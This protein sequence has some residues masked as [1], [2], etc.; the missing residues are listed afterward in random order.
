[1]QTS[2]S[3]IVIGCIFLS[4][5]FISR[6]I[7]K[8]GLASAIVVG[9]IKLSRG[10]MKY[11]IGL[12]VLSSAAV[13]SII[14]NMITLLTLLPVLALINEQYKRLEDRRGQLS[15]PIVIAV[16]Y[17]SN[18]GGM[19]SI[20]GSPANA[21]FLGFL[22]VIEHRYDTVIAGKAGITLFTWLAFGVPMAVALALIAWLLI[23]LLLVPKN[24]KRTELDFAELEKK[25]DFPRLPRRLG[26]WFSAGMLFLWTLISG[27]QTFFPGLTK[28][29]AALSV[30]L[31]LSFTL[32]I[33]LIK[34]K[35]DQRAS[36][37]ILQVRDCFTGLPVQGLLLALFAGAISG[38]SMLLKIPN[39]IGSWISGLGLGSLATPFISTVSMA[40]FTSFSTEFLSNTLVAFNFFPIAYT[41]SVAFGL[42]P[43]I[44]MLAVSLSTTCAF[45]SPIATPVNA[46]GFGSLKGVSFG[47]M[48]LA[49]FFMNIVS[50][51]WIAGCV[52]NI[53]PWLLPQ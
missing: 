11:L 29:L 34:I 36:M 33:F 42:N 7:V 32:S 8:S 20:I 47:K 19:A 48:A 21:V 44:S 51:L 17:G 28:Y 46:L 27:F 10:H 24:L 5:F 1:M 40:L 18:I 26:L 12:L 53:V 6:I 43:L 25:P 31:T 50:S 23:Y 13:S 15:T 39:T 35:V 45:M 49:G 3:Y 52:L 22:P 30:L 37:P 2:Y 4:G 16:I 9:F 41:V 14:P 38:V